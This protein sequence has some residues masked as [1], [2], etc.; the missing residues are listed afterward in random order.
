[1]SMTRI[2]RDTG[3]GTAEVARTA[4]EQPHSH[5][6]LPDGPHSQLGRT[7][8]N[9]V[10][11]AVV[12]V[13]VV[14][15]STLS[16]TDGFY[17]LLLRSAAMLLSLLPGFLYV[18]FIE[19]RGPAVWNEYVFNLHRLGVDVPANLPARVDT[20]AHP[21]DD[22]QERNIYIQKFDG[23]YGRVNRRRWE[24]PE[25]D[26]RAA[27]QKRGHEA[28]VDETE[29][30]SVL[31]EID[32]LVP[33]LLTTFLLT[34]GWMTVIA[35]PAFFSKGTST[36][37][38]E[39]RS[40]FLGAYVFIL[41]FL[42]R[43]YFQNDLKPS[44]YLAATERLAVVP[45]TIVALHVLLPTGGQLD[46]PVAFSV[47]VFPVMGLRAINSLAARALRTFVPSVENPYPL[48]DLDGMT[49]WYEARLLEEGIEDMQSLVTANVVDLM[50]HTRIPVGRLADWMD[51]AHL[52][53][54]LSPI[55]TGSRSHRLAATATGDRFTL[56]R[57][58]IRA[59]TD[60]EDAFAGYA[61]RSD[62]DV[63]LEP[64]DRATYFGGLKY[65]LNKPNEE[66]SVTLTILRCLKCEPT[67]NLVRNWKRS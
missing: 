26:G 53:L 30:R 48:S 56:R 38:D 52:Y 54:H 4:P 5:S 34:L 66:P 47:G 24:T 27:H 6:A 1:M 36:L 12:I 31:R 2:Q 32:T 39:V 9:L 50:L 60:L 3:N 25:A 37:L 59:A 61:S 57:Y 65:L 63:R 8:L 18:R 7:W 13:G 11:L 51:Q 29:D 35:S 55:I 64:D 16:T 19:S 14:V 46:I 44:A 42:V 20:A 21:S 41:Q 40:G 33:V 67:L 49:I 17:V 43:R 10:A 15:V 28:S 58:G 22:H 23:H 45:I 62:D